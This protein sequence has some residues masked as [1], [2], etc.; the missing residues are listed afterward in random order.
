VLELFGDFDL[1]EPRLV[2]TSQWHPDYSIAPAVDQQ[3][4]RFIV[5]SAVLVAASGRAV[6]EA[7]TAAMAPLRSA[8]PAGPCNQ[9]VEEY[10]AVRRR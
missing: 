4:D 1:V 5:L 2:T 10:A 6:C 9:V 3:E 7:F 8:V